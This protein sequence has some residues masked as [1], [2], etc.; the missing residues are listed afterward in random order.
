MKLSKIILVMAA[1]VM[2]AGLAALASAQKKEEEK[3]PI[4]KMS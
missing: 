4:L 1:L 2:S 3:D